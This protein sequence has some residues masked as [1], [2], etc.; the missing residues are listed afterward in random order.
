L[1]PG[2]LVLA[3]LDKG[4]L[5]GLSMG[6]LESAAQPEQLSAALA[7]QALNLGA[8]AEDGLWLLAPE[9]QADWTRGAG[10]RRLTVLPGNGAGWSGV[11]S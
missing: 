5:A 11:L 6:R 7:R 2:R 8:P 1:E 3:R 4:R 10:S 9:L